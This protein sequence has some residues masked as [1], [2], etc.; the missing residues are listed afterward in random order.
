MGFWTEDQY[1]YSPEADALR[2]KYKAEYDYYQANM[3]PDPVAVTAK[4]IL[5]YKPKPEAIHNGMVA[6]G[7]VLDDIIKE[8]IE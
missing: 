7:Y 5:K 1:D 4:S 6:D 2:A 8:I 3:K